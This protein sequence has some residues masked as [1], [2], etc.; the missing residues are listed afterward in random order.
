MELQA[1]CPYCGFT[2]ANP[3]RPQ[4]LGRQ[5]PAL[6]ISVSVGCFLALMAFGFSTYRVLRQTG[7]FQNEQD[8]HREKKSLSRIPTTEIPV[9]HGSVARPDEFH[10]HGQ[11]YFVPVG[12]QV[13]APGT[14]AG[15][16][17][18][19]FN[20]E[21]TVLPQI[22]IKP[23]DCVPVRKQCVAEDIMVEMRD[24]YPKIARAPD[25]VMIALTDE[26]IFP[27]ELGWKF[28]YSLHSE[29]FGVVS[30]RRMDPAFWGEPSKD[31][32]RLARTK[33]MLTKYVAILY[34]HVSESF[35]P[36]SVMYSPLEPNGGADDIYES[37][38]HSEES[39]NGRRGKPFPCLFFKYSYQTHEITPEEPVL[40]NCT[41]AR[42][43]ASTEEETFQTNLGRGQ[44]IQ[45][46]MDFQLD[47]TPAIEFRRAY[48]SDYL[49]PM[50]LGAGTN[51]SYNAWLSSDGPAAL[52][53]IRIVHEDGAQENLNRVS[54]GRGFNDGVAF[55][56]RDDSDEAYRGRMTWDSGHF[57][58]KYR[59]GAQSTFL[60]CNDS[61][62]YWIGYQDASGNSLQFERGADRVLHGLTASDHQ[63][64]N[65]QSDNQRR[66][67]EA[68]ASNGQHISYEYDA[69]G[70]LARVRHADGQ[71]TLYQYDS[72][73]HMTS[74]S[75]VRKPG[76]APET[77]LTN[78]YDSQGRVVKQTLAGV[79]SYQ[80]QYIATQGRDSSELKLTD[81]AGQAF[82][83]S[84]GLNA[85]IARAKPV[86]FHAA[87][88]H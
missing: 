76:A 33:Q 42:P 51:H 6:L 65:F 20:I 40:T 39:V 54:P 80:I 24:A 56:G 2:I 7:V 64:I 32:L 3:A 18:E 83:I 13:I 36:T 72:G 29:R 4:S 57:Q 59:D 45:R 16:Y 43:V 88:R 1:R 81:P 52:T 53:Y 11:L 19:K 37:D 71:V 48:I 17:R 41:F 79:G 84:I 77:I 44:L 73:N 38:L 8:E 27:R 55:E 30:T 25:S 75:V 61:S 66:I 21:I 26:D 5:K 70:C 62:C 50:A 78:E 47:S 74:V 15:Y 68:T 67:T 82:R 34:F 60:P 23:S 85:W 46:S 49:R 87:L 12:R 28:T 63:V 10:A 69:A 86:K 22:E 58:L 35:D 9:E 31:D 14:L